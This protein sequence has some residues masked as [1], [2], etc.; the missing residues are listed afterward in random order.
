[1]AAGKEAFL[2]KIKHRGAIW[3]VSLRG[4]SE[5]FGPPMYQFV[6][7]SCSPRSPIA[8]CICPAHGELVEIIRESGEEVTRTSLTFVLARALEAPGT[9]DWGSPP[10]PGGGARRIE[11]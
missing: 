3:R 7:R 4:G 1:M 2:T 9:D 8:G 6:F 11:C 5:E 10:R